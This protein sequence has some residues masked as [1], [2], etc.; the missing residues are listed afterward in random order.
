VTSS[1]LELEIAAPQVELVDTIGA[2]D[3]FQSGLLSGLA[4]AGMLSRAAVSGLTEETLTELLE[5]ALDVAAL[6][7]RRA[8][9]D[10]PTSREYDAFAGRRVAG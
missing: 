3:A 6:T 7:C 2:G 1:G 10:P 5:R 9:A 8:G 4:H